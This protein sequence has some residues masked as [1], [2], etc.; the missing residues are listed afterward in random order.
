MI[1]HRLNFT[2]QIFQFVGKVFFFFFFDG[3]V[4]NNRGDNDQELNTIDQAKEKGL[5]RNSMMNDDSKRCYLFWTIARGFE[6]GWSKWK[7]GTWKVGIT[8]RR[9]R[10]SPCANPG[11]RSFLNAAATRRPRDGEKYEI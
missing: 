11:K 2:T 1:D 6:N 7:Q 9:S 8:G 5:S 4:N 3:Q 10:W